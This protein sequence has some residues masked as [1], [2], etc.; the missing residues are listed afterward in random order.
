[1]SLIERRKKM[2]KDETINLSDFQEQGRA[3]LDGL[4]GNEKNFLQYLSGYIEENPAFGNY[5]FNIMMSQSHFKN[6]AGYICSEKENEGQMLGQYMKRAGEIQEFMIDSCTTD[7]IDRDSVK[8][9]AAAG[10]LRYKLND[11]CSTI[12]N[13]EMRTYMYQGL[14]HNLSFYFGNEEKLIEL[15][16]DRDTAKEVT[17]MF[18][19]CNKYYQKYIQSHDVYEGMVS[20]KRDIDMFERFCGCVFDSAVKVNEDSMATVSMYCNMLNPD[21]IKEGEEEDLTDILSRIRGSL[22]KMQLDRTS[23]DYRDVKV[24]IGQFSGIKLELPEKIE[25]RMNELNEYYQSIKDLEGKEYTDAVVDIFQQFI[26]IHPYSDGNG[27]S[28]RILFNV[29][30]LKKGL[31][32]ININKNE[33]IPFSNEAYKGDDTKLKEYFYQ[34]IQEAQQMKGEQVSVLEDVGKIEEIEE[35]EEEPEEIEPEEVETEEFSPEKA[36]EEERQS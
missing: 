28:S 30:L 14:K 17:K 33:Y 4:A 25:E 31:V 10:I 5:L 2:D 8:L 15:G 11:V 21:F 18:N 7:K 26:Q 27:R 23:N 3:F 13:S 24:N 20:P 35:P 12:K 29:L 32:P 6:Y 9:E 1:M 16:V 34:K 19:I 22:G 36:A